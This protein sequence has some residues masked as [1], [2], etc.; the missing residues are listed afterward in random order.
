MVKDPRNKEYLSGGTH[1]NCNTLAAEPARTT[2]TMN[3]I[4]TISVK[5]RVNGRGRDEDKATYAGR[6]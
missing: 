6:S 4:F 2:D 3:I 5:R 1:I